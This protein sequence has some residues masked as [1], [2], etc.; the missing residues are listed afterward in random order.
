MAYRIIDNEVF[1]VKT[2]FGS[3]LLV[4]TNS[5]E[6]LYDAVSDLIIKGYDVESVTE[7]RKNGTSPR[8]SVLSNNDFRKMLKQKKEG[9]YNNDS[10]SELEKDLR[11]I[12]EIAEQYT[13][14]WN[15]GKI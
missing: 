2:H 13:K 4:E 9:A 15:G 1:R 14:M 5:L 3:V 8:V 6:G 12:S 10:Q 11:R 7:L